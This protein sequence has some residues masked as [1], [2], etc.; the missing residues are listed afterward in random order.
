MSTNF[1]KTDNLKKERKA[2]GYTYLDMALKLGYTSASTYMYIEKGITAP[3]L[4][5]MREIA[6][7]LKKPVGYFFDLDIQD[8]QSNRS[9]K[10]A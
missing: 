10:G 2:Q 1:V 6:K 9:R 4:P 8:N 5:I 3:I 7:I